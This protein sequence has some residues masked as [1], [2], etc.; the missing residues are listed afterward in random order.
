MQLLR[1]N[2]KLEGNLYIA[3]AKLMNVHATKAQV[4]IRWENKVVT[5]QPI[6]ASLY[7]G[8][9]QGMAHGKNLSAVPRWDWDM[10]FNQ[11]QLKP[12]LMMSMQRKVK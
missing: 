3:D 10:Q 8:T 7:D 5:L 1:G 9:L 2:Q 4:G 11:I 6:T 12:L